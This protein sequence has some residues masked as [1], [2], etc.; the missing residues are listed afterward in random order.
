[1]KFAGKALSPVQTSLTSLLQWRKNNVCYNL[2]FT[3]SILKITQRG[4]FAAVHR[5][6]ALLTFADV[7][8]VPSRSALSHV[9]SYCA[10]LLLR[11][12]DEMNAAIHSKAGAVLDSLSASNYAVSIFIECRNVCV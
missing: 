8:M 12:V 3:F 7:T 9:I 6:Q 1:M 10:C 5:I 4:L 11:G 2:A